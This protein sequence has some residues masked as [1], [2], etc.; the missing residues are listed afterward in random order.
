MPRVPDVAT[1]KR[2]LSPRLLDIDG[3]SGMGLPRGKLTV[4]LAVDSE[5]VRRRVQEL[6]AKLAP[7]TRPVF[8]V[9]GPL[10][11]Q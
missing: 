7:G 8:E 4:Y 2:R 6:I 11:S 9:T 5:S 10:R 1:L 3:V